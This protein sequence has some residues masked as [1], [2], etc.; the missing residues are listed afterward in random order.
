MFIAIISSL[1]KTGAIEGNALS[2]LLYLRNK[3]YF[4]MIALHVFLHQLQPEHYIWR[5]EWIPVEDSTVPIVCP[6]GFSELDQECK[7]SLKLTTVDQGNMLNPFHYY[8]SNTNQS[9]FPFRK[10]LECTHI[11]NY[12]ACLHHFTTQSC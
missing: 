2:K 10:S 5:W 6:T 9:F 12:I 4:N 1:S 3:L 7:I 11:I 8:I